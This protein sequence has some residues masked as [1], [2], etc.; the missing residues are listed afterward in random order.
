MSVDSPEDT[1]VIFVN[2]LA[3]RIRRV[4]KDCGIIGDRMKFPSCSAELVARARTFLRRSLG[5]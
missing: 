4:P 1:A 3:G 5:C 2:E